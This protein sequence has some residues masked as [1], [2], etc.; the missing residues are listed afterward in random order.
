[1]TIAPTG[2]TISQP[3]VMPTSPASTPLSVNDSDGLPYFHH[4]MNMVATPPAAAARLVVRN[5]WLMAMRFTSPEAAS[6]EPGLN[7]NH[8]SQ[9]MN[10]PRAAMV[11]LCPGMARLLP[12]LPYLPMRGPNAIAPIMANTPPTL[13]TIAEPAKSWNTSPKVL[14][15]KLSAAA[16]Q[17]HPPPQVQ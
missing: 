14:I 2:D 12:S 17:S 13:C 5:T 16:L 7:P 10:T 8:P 4:V 6:C 9:R 15:I 3:A 11:R 1:M